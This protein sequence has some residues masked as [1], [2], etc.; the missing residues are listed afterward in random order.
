M[1]RSALLTAAAVCFFATVSQSGWAAQETIPTAQLI[2]FQSRADLLAASISAVIRTAEESTKNLPSA[3]RESAIQSAVQ[4][5]IVASGD[6]PRIVLA[7]LQAF[8]LCPTAQGR[9]SVTLVPVNCAGLKTPASS[10]ARQALASLETVVLALVDQ[11]EAP[12][13]LGIGGV[14]PYTNDPGAAPGG[15]WRGPSNTGGG[16]SG[17]GSNS[18]GGSG[19]SNGA[20]GVSASNTPPGG[21]GGSAP[22]SID[23]D[24]SPGGGGSS[25]YNTN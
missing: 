14:A 21:G 23:S 9:Y 1:N 13:S 3:E 2:D 25:G 4:G 8:G 17:S 7:V 22:A 20:G 5:S 19:G 12:G 10:E 16:A 6:D 15:G 18:S 24:T 11:N